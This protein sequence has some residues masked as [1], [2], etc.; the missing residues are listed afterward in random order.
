VGAGAGLV[1]CDAGALDVVAPGLGAAPDDGPALP[2]R[3]P[4]APGDALLLALGVAGADG[5]GDC[6]ED[7]DDDD[8]V[9]EL[10][11]VLAAV[12]ANSVVMP[13]AV[14]TLSSVARQVILD[15]LTSPESRAAARLRCLMPASPSARRLRAHQLL[16][17]RWQ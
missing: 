12:L 16:F 4:L 14:T 15:S 7:E 2:V 10:V 5:A 3:A 11:V 9:P 1:L 17:R 8:V 6:D 13:K